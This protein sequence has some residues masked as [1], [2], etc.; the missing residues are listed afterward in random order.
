[1]KVLDPA[2]EPY[3]DLLVYRLEIVGGHVVSAWFVI[4]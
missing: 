1:M 3:A 4:G 2:G